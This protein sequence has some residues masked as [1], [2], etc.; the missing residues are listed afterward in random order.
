M[1]AERLA[2]QGLEWHQTT[3]AKTETAD[4]AIRYNEIVLLAKTLGVSTEELL[5]LTAS[6]ETLATID[7]KVRLQS[8][9][10]EEAGIIDELRAVKLDL[11]SL[12]ERRAEL[13][14]RRRSVLKELPV[15]RRQY[16]KASMQDRARVAGR[17]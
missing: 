11:A 17:D 7:L 14:E 4:R 6:V 9:L 16:R 8:L 2:A 13:E 10:R 15:I 3:V 5:G 1:F 12:T